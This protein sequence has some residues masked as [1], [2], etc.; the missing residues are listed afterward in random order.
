VKALGAVA[1]TAAVVFTGVGCGKKAPPLP[2]LIDLPAAP[3][4]L[5]ALRRAST[6]D[7]GFA[8]PNANTDGSKPADL[9]RVDVYTIVGPATVP[10]DEIVKRGTRVGRVEV[11]PPPD[12]DAEKDSGKKSAGDEEAEG[13]GQGE[14]VH[15]TV[16]FAPGP[17]PEPDDV[18]SYV[19]VGYN[20]RGR[21]GAVSRRAIVG[22]TDAPPAPGE[23]S[24]TYD[25]T[26]ITVTWPAAAGSTALTYNVYVAAERES[27]QTEHPQAEHQ[28]VDQHVEWNAERC[29]V[30]RSVVVDGDRSAES[31]PSP[32]ACVTPK[33]TFPPKAPTG[34]QAIASEAAVNLIW[35]GNTETDLA[36]Y[37]VLRAIAPAA[38][39]VP[40][41]PSPIEQPTFTDTVPS[42]AQVTY[43]VQAVDKAGN[44]SPRSASVVETAR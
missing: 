31:E 27:R 30:V 15:L 23:P 44:V 13:I 10:V 32:P 3:A 41:T 33:D 18:R 42:G 40:V 34:L 25:E 19:A 1:M 11:K 5:T 2:P 37:I 43:V 8:V 21:R 39:V 12:P 6:V 36:G 4:D 7:L 29:Y 28:F 20:T 38:D 9:S 14:P 17:A 24:I 16:P 26:S 35:D 22:L